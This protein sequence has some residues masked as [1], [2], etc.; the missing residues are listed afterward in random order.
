MRNGPYRNVE[1]L[2]SAFDAADEISV[3]MRLC[4]WGSGGYHA[5]P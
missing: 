1:E 5:S 2:K 3:Q 4:A